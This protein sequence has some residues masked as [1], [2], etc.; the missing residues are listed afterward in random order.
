MAF[1][2]FLAFCSEYLLI[3]VYFT[4]VRCFLLLVVFVF[5]CV[6]AINLGNVFVSF[7]LENSTS[8]LAGSG[9]HDGPG[10][11]GSNAPSLLEVWKTPVILNDILLSIFTYVHAYV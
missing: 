5:F 1:L 11:P 2:C 4:N 3:L 7:R 8:N 10:A 6:A 9:Q